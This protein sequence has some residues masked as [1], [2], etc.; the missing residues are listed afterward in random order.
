MSSQTRHPMPMTS[1]G[2]EV[3]PVEISGWS[4]FAAMMLGIVGTLNV[5]YGIAAINNANF[6]V[7]DAKFVLSNLNLWGWI[8]LVSGVVQLCAMVSIFAGTS[9]GRWVGVL[10]A[11]LN[12]IAQLL[13]LPSSPFLA[14]VLFSVD[15]L[16]MY[17]LIAH[18]G[19]QQRV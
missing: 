17:G 5:V 16:V 14:V 11:A 3:Q 9:W 4:T 1:H 2:G 7:N 15:V 13:F 8:L 12:S 19:R 18:G 10:T 6:Y